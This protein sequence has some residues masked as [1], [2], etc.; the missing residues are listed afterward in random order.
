MCEGGASHFILHKTKTQKL[1][2]TLHTYLTL[3]FIVFCW[4]LAI[5]WDA[6]ILVLLVSGQISSPRCM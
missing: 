3:A 4:M 6:V 1:E 5:T 2:K